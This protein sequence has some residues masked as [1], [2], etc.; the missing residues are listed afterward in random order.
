MK[1]YWFCQTCRN[2]LTS[3]GA[4]GILPVTFD[5]YRGLHRVRDSHN[6]DYAFIATDE[7]ISVCK[8]KYNV[9]PIELTE[10]QYHRLVSRESVSIGLLIVLNLLYSSERYH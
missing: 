3:L 2:D 10:E 6:T 4:T 9:S 5:T 7:F 8:L 1:Y